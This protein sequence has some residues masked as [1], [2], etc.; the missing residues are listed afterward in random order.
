[1][2]VATRPAPDGSS[3]EPRASRYSRRR[4]RQSA[5]LASLSVFLPVA[6]IVVVAVTKVHLV[7]QVALFA[8]TTSLIFAFVLWHFS[9]PAYDPSGY[10]PEEQKE[11]EEPEEGE[12]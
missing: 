1:M 3:D 4:R 2:T 10:Y 8:G 7:F 5:A 9:D 12:G 6:G 11:E